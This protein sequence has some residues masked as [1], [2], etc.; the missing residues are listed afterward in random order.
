[1]TKSKK[2][3]VAKKRAAVKK[4]KKVA[5]ATAKKAA[6]KKPGG[7]SLGVASLIV[8]T[9]GLARY[10]GVAQRTVRNYG[11]VEGLPKLGQNR[12]DLVVVRAW[13]IGRLK[14]EIAAQQIDDR[15]LKKYSADER[16]HRAE[17]LRMRKLKMEGLLIDR[18]EVERN[19]IAKIVAVKSGLEMLGRRIAG[20][21]EVP[22]AERIV[23]EEV[24]LCCR[25]FGGTGGKGH[26]Q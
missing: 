22:G 11:R 9:A 20:R 21:I 2:K 17:L 10:F 23:D 16:E 6:G 1:M 5:T 14:K 26:G 8:D 3:K 18:K 15:R 24:E 19:N 7:S 4:K 12:Y 25:R 13:E